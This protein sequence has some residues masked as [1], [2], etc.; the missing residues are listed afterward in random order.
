MSVTMWNCHSWALDVSSNVKLPVLTTRCWHHRVF[1]ITY[2]AIHLTFYL[3]HFIWQVLEGISDS[4]SGYFISHLILD[5]S[6]EKLQV[7]ISDS[8]SRYFIL[9]VDL[10]EHFIWKLDLIPPC[11]YK[12]ALID[13]I[14][15]QRLHL[16]PLTVLCGGISESLSGNVIW[17]LELISGFTLASQRS[18]PWK[19]Q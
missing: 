11:I 2:L 16:L 14:D 12:W 1:L 8:L 6:S 9:Q 10:V 15:Q 3:G 4:L 17:K 7:G 5:T 19:S 13:N 18:F